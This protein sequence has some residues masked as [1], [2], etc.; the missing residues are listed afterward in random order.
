MPVTMWVNSWQQ[1]SESLSYS[2]MQRAVL[3]GM[4]VGA[5]GGG[6]GSLA[7]VRQF[8]F[9]S[10]TVSHAALLGVVI[11][12]AL[13]WD[14][15]W[16]LLPFTVV[17]GVGV[18]LLIRTTGLWSDTVLNLTFSGSLAVAVI[19]L[20]G[21][22]GY[23]GN[24]NRVLFG[25]ILAIQDQDIWLS[26]AVLMVALALILVSLRPHLVV[27]L[28]AGMAKAQGIPIRLY[29]LGFGVLL[30]LGVA[31]ATKAVG[32]LLVNAFLVI[33]AATSRL[34]SRQFGQFIGMAMLGGAGS[35]V[36]G[37]LVAGMLNWPAGPSVVVAQ[38]GLFG[39]ALGYRWVGQGS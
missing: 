12:A 25:D 4:I 39:L 35:A 34:L 36:M 28:H 18:L 22:P 11:S 1:L 8:S 27:I 30:S 5:L 32:V 23:R 10:H 3:G 2:F 9:F 19:G 31:V 13:G 29:D 21:L 17:F 7:V 33:P 15:T 24:L 6:L 37:I 38:I 20:S 26:L 16:V 14:P